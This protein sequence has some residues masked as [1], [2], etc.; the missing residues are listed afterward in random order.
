MQ[1]SRRFDIASDVF[2]I[3]I[4]FT[5][6]YLTKDFIS[7]I[8]LS[9]AL[10]YL[11]RP[12]YAGFLRLTKREGISSSFS[13]IIIFAVILAVLFGL[14]SVL[15][16]EILNIERSGALA[17]IKFASISENLIIWME[18][19]LPKPIVSNVQGVGNIPAFV[20]SW[21][22]PIAETQLSAIVSNLPL[23]SAETIAA[24]I[25]TYYMLIDGKHILDQA[26][27]LLPKTRRGIFRHFLKE[28]DS[29]YTTLFTVYFGVA[30]ISGILAALGFYLLGIPNPLAWGM[31]VVIFALI[32]IIGPP[33]VYVPMAVYYFL[34]EDYQRGIILLVFGTIV[35]T[36]IPNN[37]I[38]PQLAL[39]TAKIHPILT[40]LAFVGPIFV[41]GIAGV[42]V[43][44]IFYGLFLAIYRTKMLY[45]DI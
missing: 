41:I 2:A 17:S 40:L 30:I 5:I 34:I 27:E 37:I 29:I 10:I 13:L 19:S 14:S 25:F 11:N 42:I 28:L 12:M 8:P 38:A 22:I 16:V 18:G 15:L 1:P 36:L 9:I 32:P 21:I 45:R 23:L 44:P 3:M 6:I 26:L 35:I 43:G 24:I 39:R 31:L 20:A 4:F 33:G 7:A